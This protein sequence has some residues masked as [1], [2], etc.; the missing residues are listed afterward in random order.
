MAIAISST[1]QIAT[2]FVYHLFANQCQKIERRA[3]LRLVGFGA[4][5]SFLSLVSPS[6]FL[7]VVVDLVCPFMSVPLLRRKSYRYTHLGVRWHRRG[8]VQQL[9]PNFWEVVANVYFW[10]PRCL[11]TRLNSTKSLNLNH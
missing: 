10:L 9:F 4:R 3:R 2:A 6:W 1:L 11:R 7:I 8:D 5:R